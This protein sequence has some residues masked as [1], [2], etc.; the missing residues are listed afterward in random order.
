MRVTE[1]GQ[2]TIPKSLR[3]ELGIAEGT[4]VQFERRGDTLVLRKAAGSGRG[5]R[6]AT[7]LR[8]RGD[9]ALSTDQIMALT[10]G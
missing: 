10:R 2:I 5:R 8:G 7:R 4:E 1:K 3:D 9:V 6:I